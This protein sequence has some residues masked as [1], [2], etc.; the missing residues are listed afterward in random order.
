MERYD[1]RK[2]RDRNEHYT[3]L[4]EHWGIT[5]IDFAIGYIPIIVRDTLMT[6][7]EITLRNLSSDAGYVKTAAH[8]YVS[9]K[10]F[11]H[12]PQ[13]VQMKGKCAISDHVI[14]RGDFTSVRIGRYCF[15]GHNAIIR[16]PSYQTSLDT[17]GVPSQIQFLPLLVGNHTHIGSN[18]IIESSAIGS[19]VYIGN[20]CVISKR[21]VIKDCCYVHDGTVIPP[22]TIIPPFSRVA[23]TPSRIFEDM[24]PESVA[25]TSV[26]E[27]VRW[28]SE[29][30]QPLDDDK[31][32]NKKENERKQLDC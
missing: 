7:D 3:L 30:V 28:F 17:V 5:N 14:I 19:S 32:S 9:R 26:N 22:D 2:C 13:N 25:V 21:A 20:S 15:I 18:C 1:F 8:N 4:F 10:A 31:Y 16:P 6:N 29:F 24:L 12:G 23:G 11:V 27:R